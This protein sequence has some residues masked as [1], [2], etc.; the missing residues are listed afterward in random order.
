MENDT[1]WQ[2]QTPVA[3]GEVIKYMGA[4]KKTKNKAQ[5]SKEIKPIA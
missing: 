3:S 5:L 4:G 2:T 1:L